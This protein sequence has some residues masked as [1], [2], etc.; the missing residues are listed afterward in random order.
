MK[1]RAEVNGSPFRQRTV[2]YISGKQCKEAPQTKRKTKK[3]LT[4]RA[5]AAAFQI[6]AK[7]IDRIIAD[8]GAAARDKENSAGAGAGEA[9][10]Q[11]G[12]PAQPKAASSSAAS[13]LQMAEHG[14]S[15]AEA[16]MDSIPE[17]V[18]FLVSVPPTTPP[19]AHCVSSMSAPCQ[20]RGRTAPAR[21]APALCAFLATR[22]G[23]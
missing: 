8:L 11:E 10:A 3:T 4:S 17:H 21:G 15:A 23:C 19:W 18:R 12:A 9:D 2:T 22:R 1:L 13:S 7:H 14:E 20:R 5:K 6:K 16:V